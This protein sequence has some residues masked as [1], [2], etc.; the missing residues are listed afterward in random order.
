MR[1]ALLVKVRIQIEKVAPI[2]LLLADLSRSQK[3]HA[4]TDKVT[5]RI[6]LSIRDFARD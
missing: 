5:F 6:L 4:V 3:S 2:M 1:I